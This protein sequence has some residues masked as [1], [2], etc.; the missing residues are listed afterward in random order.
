MGNL[1][2]KGIIFI[3]SSPSGGGKTTLLRLVEDRLEG[4]ADSISYTTRLRRASEHDGVDYHFLQREEFERRI[5]EGF[6]AEWARV[7]DHYYGT[8]RADLTAIIEGGSDAIMDIDVQG[9]RQLKSIFPE[10]VTIFII[11]PTLRELEKRL[12]RRATETD[13]AIALRL[14]TARREMQALPE[15]DYFIVNKDLKESTAQLE[16]VIVAER[17]RTF[18]QPVAELMGEILAPPDGR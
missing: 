13:E 18:R 4:L 16:A 9:A 6:F 12:R 11:P 10:A 17:R 8:G 3:L 14:E 1:R 5:A 7:H 15:Y 2:R